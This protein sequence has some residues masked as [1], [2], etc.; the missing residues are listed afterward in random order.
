ML[1][2]GTPRILRLVAVLAHLA[3]AGWAGQHAAAEVLNQVKVSHGALVIDHTRSIA[4]ITRAQASGG[5]PAQYGLGLFLNSIEFALSGSIPSRP[6]GTLAL[7]TE[8]STHPVIYVASEFP[9]DSC[10]YAVVLEHERKHYR[11]DLDVLRAMPD[12]MRTIARDAFPA[13]NGASAQEIER[14]RNL[15]FQRVK[16]LYDAL[17]FPQHVTI[18]NP[19]SYRELAGQCG[20]EI[21]SR[22]GTRQ[23]NR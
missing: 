20:G 18:D 1:L 5:R 8:V 13:G 2:P 6:E 3:L 11:F 21:G 22:L 4:Q 19:A 9:K 12:Q 23:A 17:S 14:A 7:T 10:A 16:H 15:Y